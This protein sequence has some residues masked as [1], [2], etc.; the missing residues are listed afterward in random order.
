MTIKAGST[1]M[2]FGKNAEEDPSV[3]AVDAQADKLVD[4]KVL[5]AARLQPGNVLRGHAVNAH[6][7][8]LIG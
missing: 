4:G 6:G 5:H 8:K 1:E 3:D 7:D 2:V